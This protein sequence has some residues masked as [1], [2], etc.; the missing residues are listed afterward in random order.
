MTAAAADTAAGVGLAAGR[1]TY[2]EPTHS[3]HTQKQKQKN[4]Q[5]QQD[6][7]TLCEPISEPRYEPDANSDA[8]PN[9]NANTDPNPD[10]NPYPIREKEHNTHKPT[11][12]TTTQTK[13]KNVNLAANAFLSR[14]TLTLYS[15]WLYK[16][17]VFSTKLHS[18]CSSR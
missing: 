17:V 12:H 14:H 7:T 4:K 2:A 13:T 3:A 9:A 15:C 5:E 10:P 16:C 8:N 18:N 1:P 11:K 6:T